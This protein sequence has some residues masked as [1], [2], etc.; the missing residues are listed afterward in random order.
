ML[1]ASHRI[2]FARGNVTVEEKLAAHQ[3]MY[4]FGWREAGESLSLT[5]V[6][7]PTPGGGTASLGGGNITDILSDGRGGTCHRNDQSCPDFRQRTQLQ[8]HQSDAQWCGALRERS[9]RWLRRKRSRSVISSLSLAV[10]VANTNVAVGHRVNCW[11]MIR[12]RVSASGTL[13]NHGCN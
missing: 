5:A 7:S 13:R 9:L 12:G 4:G 6:L 1:Q 8:P 2:D 3:A 10:V 11:A